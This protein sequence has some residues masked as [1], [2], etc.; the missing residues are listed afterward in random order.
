MKRFLVLFVYLWNAFM[1]LSTAKELICL[2]LG[3]AYLG[4]D[5]VREVVRGFSG[6]L[7]GVA[8]AFV[9]KTV[10]GLAGG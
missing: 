8:M 9:T 5:G 3:A 1:S 7:Q 10:E 4:G 6:N 2:L